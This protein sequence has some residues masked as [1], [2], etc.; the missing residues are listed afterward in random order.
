LELGSEG[1]RV[2]GS[3]L[4]GRSRSLLLPT[5]KSLELSY[6][7]RSVNITTSAFQRAAHP[8]QP[9][10]AHL[11]ARDAEVDFQVGWSE[12][13]EP[14]DVF[15]RPFPYRFATCAVDTTTSVTEPSQL[16]GRRRC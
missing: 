5:R 6:D 16:R 15:G 3:L 10:F 1:R 9:K 2:E 12:G 13:R 8:Y 4:F 11:V 7:P 14:N